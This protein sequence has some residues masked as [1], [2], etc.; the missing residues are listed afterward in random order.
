MVSSF[1]ALAFAAVLALAAADTPLTTFAASAQST[2]IVGPSAPALVP[3]LALT[4]QLSV[5]YTSVATNTTVDGTACAGV[6][7]CRLHCYIKRS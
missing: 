6:S 2:G 4:T 7:P 3:A 1:G 5:V